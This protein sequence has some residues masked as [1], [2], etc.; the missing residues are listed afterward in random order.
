MFA[1]LDRL[2]DEPF[3]EEGRNQQVTPI[4]EIFEE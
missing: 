2:N 3:M 4:R 1:E